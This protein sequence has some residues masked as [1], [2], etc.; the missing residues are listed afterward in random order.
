MWHLHPV[1]VYIEGNL[2]DVEKGEIYPARITFTKTIQKIQRLDKTFDTYI[3]PGFLEGHI[4][5]EDSFMSPLEY[6]KLALLSGVTS[7]VEDPSGYIKH[8]GSE[9]LKYLLSEFSKLPI[10]F[11]YLYPINVEKNEFESGP[12]EIKSEVFTQFVHHKQCLGLTQISDAAKLKEQDPIFIK[13]ISVAK[14]MNKPIISNISK[15]HFSE[16]G[17]FAQMGIR[18]DIGSN[19]YQDAFEKACFG[20]KIKIVEG[21]SRK[22]LAGLVRL[23]KQFDTSIV[24]EDRS[25]I[26]LS[27]GYLKATLKKAVS[28]GLDPVTAIRNVTR[29]PA[30]LLGIQEGTIAEGKKANIVELVNLKD[31]EI[32]RVFYE[33]E[34]VVKQN[35]LQ[36]L[37]KEKAREPRFSVELEQLL[38]SDLIIES[39]RKKETAKALIVGNGLEDIQC[40]VVNNQ[41]VLPTDVLK[42]VVASKYSTNQIAIGFVKGFGLQRGAIATTMYGSS[43]NIIAIGTSDA[44]IVESINT[45]SKSKGGFVLIDKKR[46]AIFE[47]PILG[48]ISNLDADKISEEYKKIVVLA[49]KLGCPFEDPF[50]ALGSL[51]NLTKPFCIT[52]SGV[53]DTIEKKIVD[54]LKEE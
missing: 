13:R 52:D 38:P 20:I 22:T 31:F 41:L 5:I 3:V 26:E 29:N 53:I 8:A 44:E 32:K 9:G 50:V 11:Y 18:A 39:S 46:K 7:V 2:V 6:T 16:L 10:D 43:G 37:K 15:V 45:L 1:K 42:V 40:N 25:A 23:A 4:R 49:K 30:Q 36:I 48:T 35:K 27:K 17:R 47:L 21:T 34:C 54:I 28:L 24:S 14:S 12:E 33:G 19:V 51:M